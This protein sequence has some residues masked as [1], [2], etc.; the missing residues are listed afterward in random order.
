LGRLDE[1]M[2]D[3]PTVPI[4]GCAG[5]LAFMI[6]L[7]RGDIAERRDV[8]GGDFARYVGYGIGLGLGWSTLIVAAVVMRRTRSS[9]LRGLGGGLWIAVSV[10]GLIAIA[11]LYTRHGSDPLDSMEPGRA[12]TQLVFL[13]WVLVTVLVAGGYALYRRRRRGLWPR[14]TGDAD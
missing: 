1:Y 2:R 5:L 12:V 10:L 9:V 6:V 7:A 4:I 3:H 14:T 11:T 13:E 8:L